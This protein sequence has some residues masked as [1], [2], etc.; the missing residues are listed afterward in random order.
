MEIEKQAN[1]ETPVPSNASNQNNISGV[2]EVLSGGAQKQFRSIDH[3]Q[4][5]E[6]K[7]QSTKLENSKNNVKRQNYIDGYNDY[8]DNSKQFQQ[9][10]NI[11]Q[12]YRQ[13]EQNSR[14]SNHSRLS[15]TRNSADEKAVDHSDVNI[16][17][18]E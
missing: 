2:S 13:R 15:Q 16:K 4:I 8:V 1:S 7:R 11:N 5:M 14:L 6:K 3:N 18:L 9:T 17:A 10:Q 12:Y